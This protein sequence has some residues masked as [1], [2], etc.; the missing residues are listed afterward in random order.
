MNIESIGVALQEFV[1]SLGG[2]EEILVRVIE[3]LVAVGLIFL[4]RHLL[5]RL[6]NRGVPQVQRRHQMRIWTRTAFFL[7]LAISLAVLWLPS[8]RSLLQ[9]IALLA[10]AL[11]LTLSRPISSLLGWL[12]VLIQS[13]FRVGDRIEV[14][15]VRG[16]VVDVGLFHIHLLEINNWVDADQSTGRLI[17]LPNFVIFEGPVYNYTEAFDLIWNEIDVVLTHE[18]DWERARELLLEQALPLYQDI[19]QRTIAAAERMARQYAYRRGVT[20][21]FVYV[22]LLRDGIQLSLRYLCEPRR[23]RGTAHDITVNF[24]RLLRSEPSIHLAAPGYRIALEGPRT[25]PAM[26]DPPMGMRSD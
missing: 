16:D 2:S 18:S 11:A 6:I 19:E 9:L 25:V 13:P 14:A 7:L 15:N 8:G 24:L 26:Q 12:V 23:R 20:T 10:A 4:L 5:Y 17:H 22:K 1:G 3:T 21:P